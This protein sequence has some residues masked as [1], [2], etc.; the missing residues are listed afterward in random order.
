MFIGRPKSC[1]RGSSRGLPYGRWRPLLRHL[2]L[3]AVAMVVYS[4]GKRAGRWRLLPCA[5]M[6]VWSLHLRNLWGIKGKSL[7]KHKGRLIILKVRSISLAS[8]WNRQG[9]DQ[10]RKPC[11]FLQFCWA[12]DVLFS[13]AQQFNGAYLFRPICWHSLFFKTTN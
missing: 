6:A 9:L 13:E 8:H 12:I 4:N 1:Y 3:V 7:L 5:W 11:L 2:I 10:S